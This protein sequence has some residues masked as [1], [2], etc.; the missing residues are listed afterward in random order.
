MDQKEQIQKQRQ[1]I[2]EQRRLFYEENPDLARW[3][4]NKRVIRNIILIYWALHTI[5]TIIV[6]LQMGSPGSIV[7]EIVKLLF[8]MLWICVFVNP[9]GSWRFSLILYLWALGN[10]VML[11][12]QGKD[13]M[14]A[15][16]YISYQP[17]YGIILIMEVMV[18]FL[19]LAIA[20]YLTALPKNREL[21]E[22]VYELQKQTSEMIKKMG[23]G[24]EG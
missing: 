15:L 12:Q 10:F 24:K 4:K 23:S 2:S 3:V 8:Q 9:E 13:I 18:P 19:F 14:A 11:L 17:L 20:I 6:M 22:R 21:S 5:F 16:S 1:M 7:L